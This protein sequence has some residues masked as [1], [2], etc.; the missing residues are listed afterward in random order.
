MAL[1]KKKWFTVDEIKEFTESANTFRKK[2]SYCEYPKGTPLYESFWDEERKKCQI[3]MKASTG[4]AITG[5]HYFYLNYCKIER[6]PENVDV[7]SNEGVEADYD[8]PAFWDLDYDWFWYLHIARNGISKKDY[9]YLQL[10]CELHHSVW[11]DKGYCRGGKNL[12]VL[13]ARG[14]GFSY[15]NSSSGACDYYMIPKSKSFYIAYD[16]QYLTGDGVVDKVWSYFSHIDANTPWGKRRE[17]KDQTL[18]KRSSFVDEDNELGIK[19]EN[20]FKSEVFGVTL[21]GNPNKARGKRGRTIYWEESGQ[22]PYLKKGVNTARRS[23]ERGKYATGIQIAFGT[24][25]GKKD[26]LSGL[27]DMFYSPDAYNGLAFNNVFDEGALGTPCGFFVPIYWGY[28]GAIDEAGN[29]DFDTVIEEVLK[30]RQLIKSTSTD[31]TTL[32]NKITEDPLTPEEACLLTGDST[33]NK[34]AAMKW[35][36]QIVTDEF[37]RNFGLSVELEET[38]NGKIKYEIC[39]R[40]PIYEF[41]I[42][43]DNVDFNGAIMLYHKPYSSEPLPNNYVVVVDQYATDKDNPDRK[44]S[45]G[46]AYVLSLP[47]SMASV[48]NTICASYVARPKKQDTFNGNVVKLAKFYNALIVV[49]NDRGQLIPYCRRTGNLL[50]LAPEFNPIDKGGK[51]YG[52]DYGY[53]MSSERIKNEGETLLSEYFDD[54]RGFDPLTGKP[55]FNIHTIYDLGL[56]REIINYKRS[57]NSDRLS[58]LFGYMFY[59]NIILSESNNETPIERA[60]RQSYYKNML[61]KYKQEA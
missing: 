42:R 39:N 5:Y 17:Y 40:R 33:F 56:L 19:I 36:Q 26:D 35:E 24:G 21:G 11:D 29:S 51:L 30:E 20:G 34:E 15:K 44:D 3:G 49:E 8:F 2:G 25:G 61:S 50:L 16:D 10:T 23:V 32:E 57:V 54:I 52:R 55:I 1:I 22:N 46:A 31:N 14:K 37:L 53:S 27:K 58:A 9:E 59:L 18:H 4:T 41:P 13:K 28:E 43:S 6:V 60:E 38:K 47:N 12:F 48:K 45:L 7:D